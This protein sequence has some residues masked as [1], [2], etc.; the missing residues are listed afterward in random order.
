MKKIIW[1]TLLV[2]ICSFAQVTAQQQLMPPHISVSGVG[3]VKVKPDEVVINFGVENR[4]KQL[5][6]ARKQVDSKAA[7]VINYL[8]KQG[9]E[10]RHI[11]TSYINVFPVYNNGDLGSPAPDMYMA[12]K[13]MTVVI[14]K[15]NKFDELMSGLYAV[16]INR[17]DGISFRAADME[18]HQAEARKRAVANAKAKATMLTGELGSKI[19]RLYSIDESS[20]GNGGPSPMYKSSMRME[21]QMAE[22]SGPSI[23]GGEVVVSSLVNVTFLID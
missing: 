16:G 4:S 11:Q 23:A 5:D 22:D 17:I 6:E 2:S 19:N 9:V 21:A 10:E 8:K 18:K 14:K 20:S 1:I 13:T 7:A 3:E 15:L 12:Q